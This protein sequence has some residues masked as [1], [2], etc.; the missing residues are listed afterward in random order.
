MA[1]SN[2][3]GNALSSL[4]DDAFH[5]GMALGDGSLSG[6]LACVALTGLAELPDGSTPLIAAYDA[7]FLRNEL[8]C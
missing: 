3:E 5:Q 6:I 2:E 7:D 1:Y 4:S 8:V